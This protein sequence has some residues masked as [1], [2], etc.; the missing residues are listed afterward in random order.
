M[1]ALPS[2][3]KVVRFVGKYALSGVSRPL[4]NA[5]HFGYNTGSINA[6]DLLALANTFAT[7]FAADIAPLFS[8][9]MELN[10]LTATSLDSPT[11]PEVTIAPGII[12][13]TALPSVPAGTAAVFQRPVARRYR[14]GHSRLYLGG[15]SE[16]QLVDP[17]NWHTTFIT[18]AEAGYNTFS[19]DV[20]LG[21][22]TGY[23]GFFECNVSYYHGFTNFL[24]P[25]G[26]YRAIPTPRTT[27]LVDE[28]MDIRLNP[29]PGSQ[30]R[31]QQQG[32]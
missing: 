26:R 8:L 23:G 4:I 29:K 9:A 22:P 13:S 21:A 17:D 7:V 30:R 16:S 14:G 25:S 31:R 32:A 28:L 18:A 2:V 1:P 27:P 24:M 11:A 10:E 5:W 19:A 20:A 6:S 15:V 3:P 12:G